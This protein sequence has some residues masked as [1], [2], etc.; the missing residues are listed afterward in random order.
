MKMILSRF[1][2]D[3]KTALVTGGTR[4]IGFAIARALVEAGARV[5]VSG[6]NPD[7]DEVAARFADLDGPPVLAL[8]AELKT[9]GA[10]A[11]LVGAAT[12]QFGG[13][14][15]L[16]NNAGIAAHGETRNF[17]TAT[18]RRIM[19]VNLDAVFDAC[20]AAIAPMQ[21]GGGGV[22]LNI[23]SISGLISNIPQHQVAYNSSKAAVHMMT[24]SLASELATDNIR[25]NAIAPG[26]IMTEM[27]K[28]G[29][30]NPEWGPVWRSMTPMDRA[31]EPE[32]VAAAALFLCAPASS[33]VTGEVMVI[34][35]GYTTR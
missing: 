26:Y 15:I 6:R 16:V 18:W 7:Q 35:G 27:T 1:R 9:R 29:F 17:S 4:G 22:M 14:N 2:L 10:A 28:A 8:S 3:G 11:A 25:V 32:E 30:D 21:A 5:A 33:Y 20:R 31:G 13:L 24:K 12:E 34:D 19:A 23:G